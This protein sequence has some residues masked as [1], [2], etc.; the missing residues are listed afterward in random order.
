MTDSIDNTTNP[1]AD[2]KGKGKI[3]T[4]DSSLARSLM[5]EGRWEEAIDA[6]SE[7]LERMV[8]EIGQLSP[9]LGPIYLAYGRCLL[10]QA[11]E[12]ATP[13]EGEGL[14]N[15]VEDETVQPDE[16]GKSKL[17][18]IGHELD[19]EEEDDDDGGGDNNDDGDADGETGDKPSDDLELA[20][21]AL[22]LARLIYEQIPN[23]PAGLLADIRMDLGDVS[24]EGEAF[25]QAIDDYNVA[26]E[27]LMREESSA[28][29][30]QTRA[31][32]AALFK[33][34]MALEY[35]NRLEQ[36]MEPLSKA[37]ELIKAKIQNQEGDEEERVDLESLLPEME[38]KWDDLDGLLKKEQSI[39]ETAEPA[40]FSGKTEGVGPIND[41]SGLVKKRKLN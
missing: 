2:D 10:Q 39:L 23:C 20:W 13:F 30:N 14:D 35:A 15:K 28:A 17:I 21:E 40:E 12:K 22:D 4:I 41:L 37:I 7:I 24:M 38:A 36:A 32:A 1:V 25:D 31:L 11:I 6:F 9:Q 26:I 16:G 34:A 27:L 18:Q 8:P 29:L 3:S 5:K 33:K 19:S